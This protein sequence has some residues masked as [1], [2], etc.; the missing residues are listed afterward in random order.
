[1]L[2]DDDLRAKISTSDSIVIMKLGRHL[3]RIRA[4]LDDMNLSATYVERASLPHGTVKQLKD[5][6]EIAP[7]FSLL[8]ITKGNDPWLNR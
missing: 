3:P 4:L 8:L 7:Y 5:A 1:T 6:P 2:A